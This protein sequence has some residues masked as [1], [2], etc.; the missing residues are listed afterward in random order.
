V[1]D[2]IELAENDVARNLHCTSFQFQKLLHG[3][4]DFKLKKWDFVFFENSADLFFIAL[5]F[6]AGCTSFWTF[7]YFNSCRETAGFVWVYEMNHVQMN[8]SPLMHFWCRAWLLIRTQRKQFNKQL[9]GYHDLL[10]RQH[11]LDII[12]KRV[13]DFMQSF[14]SDPYT[15][16]HLANLYHIL[17]VTRN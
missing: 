17:T 14:V 10:R 15:M 9:K 11:S 5:C 3:K 6:E 4:L 8:L 16:L 2:D 1:T 7:F 12:F 13:M